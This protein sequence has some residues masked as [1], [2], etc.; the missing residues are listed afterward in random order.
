MLDTADVGAAFLQVEADAEHA[1]GVLRVLELCGKVMGR[2]DAEVAQGAV[3]VIVVVRS[4]CCATLLL[5][6]S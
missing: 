2:L 3:I 5:S 4:E 6:M 1:D